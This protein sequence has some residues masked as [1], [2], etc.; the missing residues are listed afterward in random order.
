[1]RGPSDGP[2]GAAAAAAGTWP[3][4]EQCGGAALAS[5][6]RVTGLELIHGRFTHGLR[7][8]LPACLQMRG[9]GVCVCVCVCVCMCELAAVHLLSGP[10][11]RRPAGEAQ[12]WGMGTHTHKHMARTYCCGTQSRWRTVEDGMMDARVGS[13]RRRT[14][15]DT[16]PDLLLHFAVDV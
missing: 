12:H 9:Q 6:T 16:P 13:P 11:Q 5:H 7:C 14:A 2:V 1:M 15:A 10:W 3:R 8:R 4:P